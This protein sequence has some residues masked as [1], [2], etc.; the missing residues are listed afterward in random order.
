MSSFWEK[1]PKPFLV[2]APMEDVTDVVFREIVCSLARPD[3]FFTEFTNAEG[4]TSKGQAAVIHRLKYTKNQRPIVAQIWG[5][6][7]K[8][9][10][11]AAELVRKLGFDGIDI[12]MGCT[13]K[14]VVK[15]GAGA[16]LI[17]NFDLVEEIISAVKKGAANLPVSVKTRLGSNKWI[18]Y[19][20]KQSLDALTIHARSA[21]ML[22]K[23]VANWDEIAEIVKIK[24]Q[25][26]PQTQII[27]NGDIKNYKQALEMHKIHKVDGIM[28]GRGIFSNP[29]VFE[30]TPTTVHTKK[31]S[32]QAL[33]KHVS[34]FKKVWGDTKNFNS[35]KKFLKMYINNFDGADAF[36]QK[37]MNSQSIETLQGNLEDFLGH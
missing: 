23:G 2:L 32:L 6:E 25:I 19:L 5:T 26:S 20:L 13:D 14:A 18:P 12:N 17:E 9:M 29:W 31:H 1:L 28:I 11:K 35:L 36:R 27:G 33:L 22:M 15:K 21:G 8:S 7:P 24:D 3:V 37:L 4:L 16:G 30:K 10:F 34:E